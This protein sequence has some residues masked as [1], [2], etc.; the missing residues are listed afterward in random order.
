MTTALKSS[1]SSHRQS[2]ERFQFR[3]RDL[4]LLTALVALTVGACARGSVILLLAAIAA[5]SV[6]LVFVWK[7][8]LLRWLVVL[9][10]LG[11]LVAVLW[12][13]PTGYI[14]PSRRVQC[15]NNLR[16]IAVALHSYHDVYG[17]LPP[18]YIA[19]ENGRPMHSWRVL[20]LPFL[21]Q[22]ALYDQYDFSEPWDG[23][24]NRK[25]ARPI[26]RV[27]AESVYA[28]PD[29][30]PSR[31]LETHYLAIVGPRT[32]FPGE[33]S[34]A[35]SEFKDG[36][37]NVLLVVEVHNSGISW[38]EP[39]DLDVTQAAQAIKATHTS[40][41]LGARRLPAGYGLMADGSI[42]LIHPPTNLRAFESMLRLDD[43]THS[44]S[45]PK[46]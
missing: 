29:A 20:I 25:L 9:A 30:V 36:T 37:E 45:G 23:P 27:H 18:A 15:T 42:R 22:Q 31:P 11:N 41:R 7:R 39:R 1:D 16:Q 46:R 14:E 34:A 28:C 6:S 19:D 32:G 40:E 33:K 38:M 10:I 13:M 8:Q 21:E 3:I 26:P 24:N 17:C 12:P 4:L 43:G 2:A 44:G 35:F 5:S